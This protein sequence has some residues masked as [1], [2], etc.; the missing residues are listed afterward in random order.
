MELTLQGG[1]QCIILFD[2]DLEPDWWIQAKGNLGIN[3][4]GIAQYA[5]KG[6]AVTQ[7]G[8][9]YVDIPSKLDPI[10]ELKGRYIVLPNVSD[11]GQH[12]V[13]TN[14]EHKNF[15]E[16]TFIGG[17]LDRGQ[18]LKTLNPKLRARLSGDDPH[19]GS[20]YIYPLPTSDSREAGYPQLGT[21]S[22][23]IKISDRT[24]ESLRQA[25]LGWKSR[26]TVE[27]PT[28]PAVVVKSVSIKGANPL[29]DCDVSFSPEFN[30]I[31]GGRGSGKSTLLEYVAFGLGRSCYDLTDKQYSGLTRL[32][33]LVKDTIIA[34]GGEVTL[35]I[36]QDGADF[37]IVRSAATGFQL[38]IRY[39]NGKSEKLTAKDIRGL[40]PA[41]AYSQGELSEL[42]RDARDQTSVNDL[43]TFVRAPF[44]AEADEAD[45]A[46]TAAKNAMLLAARE[47]AQL[48]RLTAEK[49]KAENRLAAA[50]A[51][52]T[53]LQSTLPK[54]GTE[55]QATLDKNQAVVEAGQ[56]AERQKVD[57]GEFS[58]LVTQLEARLAT[59][60]TFGTD[61]QDKAVV[62]AVSLS[63][64]AI[65][66]L[67]QKL[68]KLKSDTSVATKSLE[69]AYAGVAA[70]VKEHKKAH[71]AIV[72][73]IG[74]QKAVAKQV[75]ELQKACAVEKDRISQLAKQ[76]AA[77]GDL[78]K[79]FGAARTKLKKTVTDQIVS[80]KEF[81]TRIEELSD[82][83][84][85]VVIQEEG[86]LSEIHAALETLAAQTRSVTNNRNRAFGLQAA[87][88]GVWKT[89]DRLATEVS[90]LLSWKIGAEGDDK[91]KGE[92]D[93]SSVSTV[94]G[95]S[96]AI[97]RAFVERLDEPRYLAIA[98]AIPKPQVTFK[99]CADSKE[100]AFEKASE[101]QRAA[102]LLTMLLKQGGGPLIIDQPESDLDNSVITKVVDLMHGM[103]HKRQ[104][105][106]STHNANLVVNGAAEFVAFMNND[107]G[108]RRVVEYRGS[109]DQP[110]V[111]RSITETME[112]GEKAFKD[113]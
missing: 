45:E 9:P 84:V 35:I 72:S 57:F 82:G 34:E 31:I 112:G 12:T 104:L 78:N 74:T 24:A 28:Y 95:D 2:C 62:D 111:R 94:L 38:L 29:D 75:G 21:N 87:Q 47:F 106:F 18:T 110:D 70:F 73:K 109:I 33:A 37:Q 61:L 43:L 15:R 13:V 92:P 4:V 20:R 80:L 42:G 81:A 97:T 107:N 26:I 91:K 36:N 56:Q 32:G 51:R 71:D 11:G 93:I 48:W 100:I 7:L 10:P 101:G 98:Q 86:D 88:D 105:L 52:I 55:D 22:A 19:W 40:F 76:I 83:S 54:L 41:F 14:G 5:S 16:M 67:S 25:F 108:G 90:A 27:Q 77:L 89:L 6:A 69:K 1:C 53:A 59:M 68:S 58:E 30:A 3:H 103:K 113:R 65:S 23:W 46:I 60:Q 79:K 17:Y 39:P 66:E 49:Q 63:N 102:V 44:K 99:Y 50:T 85:S 64:K 8:Y 96:E